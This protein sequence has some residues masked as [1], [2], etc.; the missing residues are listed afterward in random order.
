VKKQ[1]QNVSDEILKRY[2]P[3]LVWE[4]HVARG[5][6]DSIH[7]LSQPEADGS[8][9]AENREELINKGEKADAE[10]IERDFE[11]IFSW[12]GLGDPWR[13]RSECKHPNARK[14]KIH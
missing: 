7:N 14:R 1:M 6:R 13:R 2:F 4:I 5:G 10:R 9:S 3:G 8:A 12:F 11:A